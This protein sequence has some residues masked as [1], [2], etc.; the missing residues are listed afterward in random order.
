MLSEILGNDPDIEIVGL[1]KDGLEGL[2]MAI[3]LR[4][5]LVTMDIQMPVMDGFESTKE[6]MIEA[7]TPIVIVSTSTRVKEVE[8]GM[9]ALAAGALTLLLKPRGPN[10]PGFD[11][12]CREIVETVKAMADVKVV[13][14]RRSTANPAASAQPRNEQQTSKSF[15]AAEGYRAIA[16]AASTGGPP[17]LNTLLGDLPADFPLPIFVVQHIAHGFVEGFASWL[18]AVIALNVRIA[19]HDEMSEAG[20]VYIAP[21]DRH[22]GVTRGGR[23]RLSDDPP[24]S[25]FRPAG[26][27]LLNSVAQAF[28]PKSVGIILT[29]MGQDGVEGMRAIQRAGG[30]TIAQNEQTSVI[31]GMPRVAIEEGVVGS[32][33]PIGA[34]A[35]HLISLFACKST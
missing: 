1:A 30:V 14:H 9:M 22:L 6:I 19:Q 7:P 3:K 5:D 23:I 10:S 8:T 31:F 24:I 32:I 29:G 17:A 12:A 11:E 21:Q 15:P 4:P 27:Y 20:T 18:D 35:R 33:L 25:G 2:Q 26:T 13:R 34:I 16:I 28:G